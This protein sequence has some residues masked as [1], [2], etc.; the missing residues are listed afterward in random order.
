MVVKCLIKYCWSHR[1]DIINNL[2]SHTTLELSTCYRPWPYVVQEFERRDSSFF[3]NFFHNRGMV[4]VNVKFHYYKKLSSLFTRVC[5]LVP[6]ASF[7]SFMDVFIKIKSAR[8]QSTNFP[9]ISLKDKLNIKQQPP[10]GL[11]ICSDLCLQTLYR[12]VL[13]TK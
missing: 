3:K 8:C 5:V 9:S 4:H 6:V 13:R 7:I 10:F 11:K 2:H 1:L 12:S